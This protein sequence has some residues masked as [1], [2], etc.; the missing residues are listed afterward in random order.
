MLYLESGDNRTRSR[1]EKCQNTEEDVAESL[2]VGDGWPRKPAGCSTDSSPQLSD[3]E[4]G[5][6]NLFIHV[7][8]LP[9]R[10]P[11]V[12]QDLGRLPHGDPAR[13]HNTLPRDRE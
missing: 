9:E 6:G 1:G 8:V 12:Q 3:H 2:L 4:I 10:L 13:D 11:I 5:I 7:H